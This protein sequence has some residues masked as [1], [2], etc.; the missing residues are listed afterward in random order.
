[1]GSAFDSAGIEW[2]ADSCAKFYPADATAMDVS[3]SSPRKRAALI[4]RI[5]P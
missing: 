4:K 1:M 5:A 3:M 2:R